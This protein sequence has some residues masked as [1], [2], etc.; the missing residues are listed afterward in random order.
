LLAEVVVIPKEIP[1]EFEVTLIICTSKGLLLPEFITDVT[2]NPW[3][4]V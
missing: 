3:R 2:S 4:N 1:M